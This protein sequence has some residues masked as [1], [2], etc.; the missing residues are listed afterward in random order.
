MSTQPGRPRNLAK[1]QFW[2]DIIRR[3]QQTD[4]PISAFCQREGLEAKA[5][6]FSPDGWMLAAAGI[7]GAVCAWILSRNSASW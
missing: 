5:I 2:R 4:L 7:E 1:E 3:Q 6:A